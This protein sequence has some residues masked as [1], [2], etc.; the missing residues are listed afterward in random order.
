MEGPS[1]YRLAG[2]SAPEETR[3]DT[4]RT[5]PPASESTVFVVDDDPAVCSFL[6]LLFE[7]VNL[8]VEAYPS[9]ESFLDHHHSERTGCLLLDVRLPG[10]SGLELLEHLR[11]IGTTIP[12]VMMTG[13]G[14]VALAVRAMKG[15][16]MD[17]LQKPIADQVLLESVHRAIDQE[18]EQRRRRTKRMDI[19][20]RI[21]TLTPREGQVMNLVVHGSGNKQ[22]ATTLGCSG[23][24]VEMHRARVMRK[25]EADGIADLV[26]MVMTVE[27]Q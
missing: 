3:L 13:Y 22:A 12:V 19:A 16:A 23:K 26:R 6:R 2:T 17:F 21:A 18:G 14:D 4:N 8:D 24:T 20:T 5:S 15:G 27:M 1:D 9:A 25:M 11:A 7:S 10:M